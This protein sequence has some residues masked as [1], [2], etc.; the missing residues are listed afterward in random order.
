MEADSVLGLLAAEGPDPRHAEKLSLFGR[1]VGSW[2]LEMTAHESNGT[3]RRFIGEWHFAWVLG[4]RGIQDVLVSRPAPEDA[5]AGEKRGGIG[6]TLRVYVPEDDTWW[7][8]FAD[9]WDREFNV[10]QASEDDGRIVQRGKLSAAHEGRRFE[11]VFSDIT[12]SSFKWHGRDS[13][14]DGRTWRLVQEISGRR[15]LG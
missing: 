10:L 13:D 1:L 7:V 8:V 5:G 14:D 2:D 11:W 4:G 15:R 6:T 12:D 3:T 9:P